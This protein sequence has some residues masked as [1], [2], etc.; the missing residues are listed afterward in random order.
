[1]LVVTIIT[2]SRDLLGGIN[3]RRALTRIGGKDNHPSALHY[4]FQRKGPLSPE[5]R[6]HTQEVGALQMRRSTRGE[7]D[8]RGGE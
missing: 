7:W 5:L 2:L 4:R 3:G 8:E 6:Y 1:M